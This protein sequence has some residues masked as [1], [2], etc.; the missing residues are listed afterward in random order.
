MKKK[1]LKKIKNILKK[2]GNYD[3]I[4]LEEIMYG[5][6]GIEI[7]VFREKNLDRYLIDTNIVIELFKELK[8]LEK[9]QNGFTKDQIGTFQRM[10]EDLLSLKDESNNIIEIYEELS[11]IYKNIEEY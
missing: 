10:K 2:Y 1:I 11:K 5:E 6:D 3:D 8:Q 9:D 7:T 4:K